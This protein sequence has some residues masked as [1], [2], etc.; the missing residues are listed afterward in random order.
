MDL[1]SFIV[2]SLVVIG[3]VVVGAAIVIVFH[4]FQLHDDLA[5]NRERDTMVI[6]QSSPRHAERVEA[7]S[8]PASYNGSTV[9]DI[10]QSYPRGHAREATGA[11]TFTATGTAI[12]V[13]VAFKNRAQPQSDGKSGN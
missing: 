12:P 3:A 13:D 2:G 1:L 11:G 6:R 7:P 8:L 5:R 4:H 10:P 9:K